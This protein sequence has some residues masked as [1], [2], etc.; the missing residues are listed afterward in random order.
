M[1]LEYNNK[2]AR[3]QPK[4]KSVMTSENISRLT[5]IGA[6]LT[7]LFTFGVA[8]QMSTATNADPIAT[9][10]PNNLRAAS[11]TTALSASATPSKFKPRKVT[12]KAED[13]VEDDGE[14]EQSM[15]NKAVQEIRWSGNPNPKEAADEDFTAIFDYCGKI[16]IDLVGTLITIACDDGNHPNG[17]EYKTEID[18]MSFGCAQ[19]MH[20]WKYFDT[21]GKLVTIQFEPEKDPSAAGEKP[22]AG[23]LDGIPGEDI[24]KNLIKSKLR[25][26]ES[27]QWEKAYGIRFSGKN[28]GIECWTFRVIFRSQN[29]FGEYSESVATVYWNNGKPID[30]EIEQP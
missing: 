17:T 15:A 2:G 30:V 20:G 12:F 29:E 4:R 22:L 26:P 19:Y 10:T 8:S 23:W 13:G 5:R 11:D 7:L 16:K 28:N 6:S 25:A 9:P 3:T 18:S 27:V 1:N 24:T 21:N 14:L